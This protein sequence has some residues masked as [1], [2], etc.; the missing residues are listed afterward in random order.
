M[1]QK[2]WAGRGGPPAAGAPCHGTNGT[3]VNPALSPQISVRRRKYNLLSSA[4]ITGNV[5]SSVID[6]YP[7]L[8]PLLPQE[9]SFSTRF[10][11]KTVEDFRRVFKDMTPEVRSMFPQVERLLCLWLISPALSCSAERS[12]SALHRLKTWLRSTMTHRRLNHVMIYHV[13]S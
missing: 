13:H 3:M 5:K 9:L 11:S 4:H 8:P 6:D 10:S 2:L 1:Q 12:I 7:K